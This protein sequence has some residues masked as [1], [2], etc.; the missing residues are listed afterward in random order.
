MNPRT[1]PRNNGLPDPGDAEWRHGDAQ[2]ADATREAQVRARVAAIRAEA[3]ARLRALI[4]DEA[5]DALEAT[6][7]EAL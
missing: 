2:R 4:G 1:L 6:E 7:M 5:A 3:R